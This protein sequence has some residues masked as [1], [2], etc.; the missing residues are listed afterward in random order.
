MLVK[1]FRK[2]YPINIIVLFLITV[3]SQI[4]CI[5]QHK[6]IL[7]DTMAP[8]TKLL[9]TVFCFSPLLSSCLLMLILFA[10]LQYTN[11]INKANILISKTSLLPPAVFA[12]LFGCGLYNTTLLPCLF[13]LISMNKVFNSADQQS[14]PENDYTAAGFMTA[15]AT[16]A[17]YHAAITL[18]LILLSIFILH[19]YKIKYVV[20]TVLGFILPIIVWIF[21]LYLNNN[22]CE[23]Q[24]V[25]ASFNFKLDFF[26]SNLIG[27]QLFYY[28]YLI[29]LMIITVFFI[30]TKLYEVTIAIR[31]K[32]SLLILY[33]LLTIVVSLFSKEA[34][35]VLY[36]AFPALAILL[37]YFLVHIKRFYAELYFTLITI[38]PL[39]IYAFL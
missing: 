27:I 37:S 10:C 38:I 6:F 35:M 31:N 22:F 19:S 1:F 25:I 14:Y 23:I 32:F 5:L 26:K 29:A 21:I 39:I 15:L 13:I 2:T 34:I 7:P 18:L 20:I 8:L 12:M 9:Y 30:I 36:L 17:N 16:L 4:L 24:N 11:V 3:G 28:I 33:I